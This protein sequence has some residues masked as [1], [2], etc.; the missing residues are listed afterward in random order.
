MHKVIIIF[1]QAMAEQKDSVK[2]TT[3]LIQDVALI[4]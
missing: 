1:L 4:G 3:A 2:V